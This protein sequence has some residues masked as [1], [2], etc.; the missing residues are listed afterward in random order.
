MHKLVQSIVALHI[1]SVRTIQSSV[2]YNFLNSHL[3]G[4]IMK[5]AHIADT[6]K[7]YLKWWK[8]SSFLPWSSYED[9]RGQCV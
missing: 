8:L 5:S 9:I 7:K 3:K 2:S 1:N 6:I 4:E